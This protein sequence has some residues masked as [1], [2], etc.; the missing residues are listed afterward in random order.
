LRLESLETR[1]VPAVVGALD[2]SFDTDGKLSIAGAPLNGVALQADG[3]VVVVGS[4]ATDFFVA[5]FNPDGSLDTAFDTDGIKTIDF[6]GTDKANAVAIQADGKI[7]VAGSTTA[8]TGGDFAVARLNAD[9]SLDT[10]FD[11]DGKRFVNFNNG[12]DQAFA[13]ALQADGKIV[14][15][16]TDNT[17]TA[18]AFAIARLNPADGSLDNTFDTDGKKTIDF[19]AGQDVAR[20]VAVQADGKIVVAGNTNS[21]FALVRLNAADGSLDNTFDTD[22]KRTI[23]FGGSDLA[24]GL[25][26]QTDGKIV[27]VGSN[28]TD[29]SVARLNPTDGGLDATFDTDGKQTINFNGADDARAVRLQP[30]G[31]IVVVGDSGA[32]VAVGRLTGAGAV[33]GKLTIDLGTASDLGTAAALTPTGRIVVAGQN[34]GATTGTLIRVTGTLDEASNLAVGGSPDGKAQ[35]FTPNPATGQYTGTAAATVAAFGADGANV[36]VAAGDVNGDGAEDT[37]LITGAGTA[38]RLAVVSGADNTTLLVAPFDPFGGDF[39]GGGFVA[40]GDLDNDG[41]AEI[42]ATPDRGGG[43]RV[44]I[45]SLNLDGS[46]ATRASFFGIADPG[47]RGGARPAV[48]DVDADGFA[49]VV[50]A[51]GFGGGPRVAV[52][53]GATVFTTRDKLINDFFAFE[54]VLRNGV[55]V[56]VG[57]INGDGFGDL[58]F[59][60]G[61]GGSPRLLAVSGQQLLTAGAVAAIGTP[62]ANFFV[63][64]ND[65]DRGG[66][67]VSTADVDGDNKAEVITGTGE[68][69]RSRVR[70]YYGK[71]FG[72]AG[73]PAG[74]QDLDPYAGAILPDGVYVG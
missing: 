68:G 34:A 36:R 72:A 14:V 47:F 7:V 39:T 56:T 6:G 21:D 18:G 10:S 40:V 4:S 73:E 71:N 41:R 19:T 26:I 65:A 57:D 28:G 16:G 58:I 33:D 31:R 54:D 11:G 43:P 61:P 23:D 29:F 22:G 45:F 5:R 48:G 35:V 70:V 46:V 2:P 64:G 69:S 50:I 15:V 55:Y 3:K 51:A 30:D 44:V 42:V 24:R 13:V 25:A 67:R 59:G 17:I 27:V 74:F 60:A 1:E 38:A 63:G 53:D 9:G 12:L 49:D 66:V 62:L 37:V 52:F 32:D 20:A 8:G